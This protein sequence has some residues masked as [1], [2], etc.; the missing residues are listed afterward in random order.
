MINCSIPERNSMLNVLAHSEYNF[1]LTGSRFF[2][3]STETSDW[4][5]FTELNPKIEKFLESYH[6]VVKVIDAY[7]DTV[8]ERV[9]DKN[10]IQIHIVDD[11]EMKK[12][13]QLMLSNNSVLINK[14]TDKQ[15]VRDI[16]RMTMQLTRELFQ[17]RK[18][19]RNK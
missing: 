13:A 3:G 14:N 1:Y 19:L 7:C 10:I 4:D 8:Y 15:H 12:F 2:G 17:A 5:F 6:F 11:I 9:I 18:A 16:W